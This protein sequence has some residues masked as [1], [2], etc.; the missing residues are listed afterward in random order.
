M[1]KTDQ[2]RVISSKRPEGPATAFITTEKVIATMVCGIVAS[3][4]MARMATTTAW[5]GKKKEAK[6]VSA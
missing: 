3:A 1:P 5:S 4:Q 6:P 2:R